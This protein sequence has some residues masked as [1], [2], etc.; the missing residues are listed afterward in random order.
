MACRH[1][2]AVW[3]A[4]TLSGVAGL[5]AQTPGFEVASVKRNMSGE[6]QSDT[7]FQGDRYM[8][9]NATLRRVIAE[10]YRVRSFQVTGGP[11]WIDSDRFEIIAKAQSDAP[12]A[13]QLGPDGTRTPGAASFLI[14]QQLL[15]ERFK[16][17]AHVDMRDGPVLAL[18][19]GTKDGRPGAQ[20]RPPAFDCAK[21]NPRDPDLPPP[22]G[23]FCG[24]IRAG[25]GSLVGK[26]ATMRQLSATLSGILQ[27]FVVDRTSLNGTFD[28]DLSWTPAPL[29]ADPSVPPAGA[30]TGQ[31]LYAALREQLGLKLD[32]QRGRVEVVVIDHVEPPTED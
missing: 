1:A 23:G 27:Q 10:A 14:V 2:T 16:L 21:F 3:V 20:L 30:E 4:F 15:K 8:A 12:F 18:V 13:L 25:A 31:S 5:L 26:S 24:G 17:A 9:H 32:S 6:T 22:P 7:V 11:A 19:S 29:T 28:L